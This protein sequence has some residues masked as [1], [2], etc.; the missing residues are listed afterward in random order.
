MRKPRRETG[1]AFLLLG[2]AVL[3]MSQAALMIRWADAPN[4][5]IGFWRQL[6]AAAVLAFFALR[7]R[8][9]WRSL[10]PKERAGIPLAGLLFFIHLWTF[11]YA[12]QHTSI[13]HTMIGFELHPVWTGLG[14]WLFFGER[15][16]PRVA[17]A[18]L[19]AAAGI[20]A[21]LS[22][23]TQG[24]TTV[25]GDAAALLAAL[26]FSGY[27]LLGKG[28]RRKLDNWVFAFGMSAVM[29]PLFLAAGLS[30]GVSFGPYPWT[31][32]AA[33]ACLAAFVSIGGHAIF[34]H[35]LATMDVN[36][37]SCAKL[38]EPALAA[39]GAWLVLG[40]RL[41]ARTVLAFALVTAA[42][43]L[44]LLPRPFAFTETLSSLYED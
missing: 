12:T 31:F 5:A 43:L 39:V 28:A 20:A 38:L 35:L 11:T 29:G 7:R 40:E 44:I 24:A 27:V 21:L 42:V 18:W 15:L 34:S 25:A 36:A 22:G 6:L 13:A 19:L 14:A 17:A 2:F 8:E 16:R 41:S 1:G 23:K 33:V 4:E 37:L 10:T 3:G 9:S 32:W 30:R 26:S